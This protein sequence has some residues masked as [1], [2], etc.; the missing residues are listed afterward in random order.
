MALSERWGGRPLASTRSA[1]GNETMQIDDMAGEAIT[2]DEPEQVQGG[3]VP[4]ER[5][6]LQP[7]TR[8]MFQL[9]SRRPGTRWNSGNARPPTPR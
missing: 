4:D 5:F 6:A 1:Q 9:S 7:W 3:G 8:T 2:L